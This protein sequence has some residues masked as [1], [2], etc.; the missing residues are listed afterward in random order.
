MNLTIIPTLILG[1]SIEGIIRDQPFPNEG[2]F[3]RS[4]PTHKQGSGEYSDK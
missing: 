1:I 2:R 3:S 4:T